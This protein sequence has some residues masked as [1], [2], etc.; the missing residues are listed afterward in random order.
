MADIVDRYDKM[1]TALGGIVKPGM[2]IVDR[3]DLI[4]ALLESGAGGGG[5]GG[6]TQ[7]QVDATVQTHNISDTAHDGTLVPLITSDGINF[8]SLNT[9]SHFSASLQTPNGIIAV[10]IL[11]GTIGGIDNNRALVVANDESLT[12]GEMWISPSKGD[13]GVSS[14]GGQTIDPAVTIAKLTRASNPLAPAV[15]QAIVG[16]IDWSQAI[17]TDSGNALTVGLDGKLYV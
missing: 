8:V 1:I 3:L 17:S 2:D 13:S 14:D 6:V 12:T 5:T 9:Q 11:E 15:A 4:V 7:G 16:Q 10:G